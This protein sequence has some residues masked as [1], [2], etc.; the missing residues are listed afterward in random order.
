MFETVQHSVTT[1]RKI[2]A[3]A[4]SC[5]IGW[6]LAFLATNVFQDYEVGLFIW[7]P[8]VMGCTSTILVAY[9]N[10]TNKKLLRNIAYATLGIFCLGMLIFAWE[11]VICLIMAAPLGLLSTYIG[12][13]IGYLVIKGKMKDNTITVMILFICSVPALMAFENSNGGKEE[14]RCVTTTIEINASPATV[15]KNVI[16]FPP[17]AEPSE[18]I[19]KSGIAYPI[20][21]QISG[22]GVGAIRHC[23]FSTG[24]F[25]EPIT[26]WDN[27]KLLKF[28]VDS[29][30]EPLKEIS[31]YNN[32]HPNHLHGYWISKG[33]QFKLTQLPN[34]HTLLEGS[35]WYINKIKPDFYWTLWSDY[36][37]HT[38]HTRVLEH[39]KMHAEQAS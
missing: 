33:G 11:G 10:Q 2:I 19:F 31:F 12:Y 15:W 4:I 28:D 30:P 24:S 21:A 9:K 26:V 38:I 34:G 5:T 3:I 20:N 18:F 17:L 37:V 7:L 13:R 6:I 22:H 39:I 25:I 36:I 8:L 1:N 29:Q 14:L 16:E 27:A 32:L 23:N 35:T